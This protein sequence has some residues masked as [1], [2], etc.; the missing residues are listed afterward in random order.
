MRIIIFSDLHANAEALAALN[1]V[2]KPPD[3]LFFLGD[4]V[5]Y[6]PEP[7]A[8]VSW[9]RAYGKHAVRGDHDHA[10]ATNADFASPDEF[11]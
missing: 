9:L 10:I 4:A 1:T 3:A 7:A 11:R 6:G 8:C 2:E 5:G